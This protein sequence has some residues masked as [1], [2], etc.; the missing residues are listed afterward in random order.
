MSLEDAQD[1]AASAP[2][3]P[4]RIEKITQHFAVISTTITATAILSSTVFLYGYL[5]VFDWRLIWI[6]EYGDVLKFGLVVLAV[7]A[8]F[9]GLY[10]IYVED[11]YD[12][13]AKPERRSFLVKIITLFFFI[14]F[15]SHMLADETG[16]EHFYML[17]ITLHLSWL[18]LIGLVVIAA[19][20]ISQKTPITGKF[21]WDN[22]VLI[23]ITLGLFGTTFGYYTRDTFGFRH[24]VSIKGNEMRDVGVVMITSHHTVLYTKDGDVLVAPTPDV[25]QIVLPHRSE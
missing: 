2:Q 18:A 16:K 4:S 22:L 12:F 1:G 10:S 9:A 5:S 6:I 24:T 13:I 17:H 3:R 21:V 20:H 19:F 8:S 23:T 25:S 7:L 14:S 11:A 15:A